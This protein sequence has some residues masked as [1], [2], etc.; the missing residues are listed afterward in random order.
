M[1]LSVVSLLV[2]GGP[3]IKDMAFTLLIGFTVGTYSSIF[4][5]SPLMI[6]WQQVATAQARAPLP[7][8]SKHSESELV[9][10]KGARV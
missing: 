10:E 1:L 4:I 7:T 8:V 3:T 9:Y 6:W 5:A 2:L